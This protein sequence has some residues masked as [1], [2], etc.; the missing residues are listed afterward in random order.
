MSAITTESYVCG[1]HFEVCTQLCHA[2]GANLFLLRIWMGG[3]SGRGARPA[4]IPRTLV[5]LEE[6]LQA[7]LRER[8]IVP[9]GLALGRGGTGRVDER[10]V[11]RR[12]VRT[13]ASSPSSRP[14]RGRGPSA[15][16]RSLVA[17]ARLRRSS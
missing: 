3:V 11:A 7:L 13:F 16:V 8:R 4:A 9:I 1:V 2:V 15:E 14:S 6:V 12:A 17:S 10:R 5:L